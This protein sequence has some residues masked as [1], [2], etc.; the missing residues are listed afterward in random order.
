MGRDVSSRSKDKG[1]GSV[2]SRGL[3]G[4]E[5]CQG[6]GE[7]EVRCSG[8]LCWVPAHQ[9]SVLILLDSDLLFSHVGILAVLI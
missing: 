8:C 7:A 9:A 3:S 6:E 2:F 5:S 4:L 1:D